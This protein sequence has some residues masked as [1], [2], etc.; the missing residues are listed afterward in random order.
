MLRDKKF[1][2]GLAVSLIFLGLVFAGQD[3]G[4]IWSALQR[5]NYLALV[6]AVGLYF[7][8]VGVRAVRWQVLLRPVLPKTQLARL[9]E[10]VVIGYMANDLLPARLGEVVRA[11]VLSRREQ[12]TKS[13]IL[14]TIVVERIF[15]GIT[16][17]GFISVA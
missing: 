14:G 16:M 5:A 12:E 1:W 17:V 8:G 15:D 10:V 3:L 13:A 4:K 11:F 6:P 9:F 2:L 7:L